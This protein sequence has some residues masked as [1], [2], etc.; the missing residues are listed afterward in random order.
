MQYSNN[1]IQQLITYCLDKFKAKGLY[2][3]D[4]TDRISRAYAKEIAR[5][6]PDVDVYVMSTIQEDGE[7]KVRTQLKAE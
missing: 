1:E 4:K 3:A 2:D 6:C 5:L 7:V